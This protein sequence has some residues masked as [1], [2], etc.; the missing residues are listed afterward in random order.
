MTNKND[1]NNL[2]V[3]LLESADGA[4]EIEQW[5]L[6]SWKEDVWPLFYQ[7]TE[8]QTTDIQKVKDS[9]DEKRF[10]F[11]RFI[12]N[13]FTQDTQLR[14]FEEIILPLNYLFLSYLSLH[15]VLD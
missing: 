4:A 1:N 10:H 6:K 8:L 9:R 5:Q 13:L 14:Q 12:Q 11:K 7:G 2:F 3:L 15:F